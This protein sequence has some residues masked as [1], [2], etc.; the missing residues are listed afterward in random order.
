MK[1]SEELANKFVSGST[2]PILDE[3]INE[4]PEHGIQGN[5]V[6]NEH[7]F[8]SHCFGFLAGRIAKIKYQNEKNYG[9]MDYY[10]FSQNNKKPREFQKS[11]TK[12]IFIEVATNYFSKLEKEI[13]SHLLTYDKKD[14]D[15]VKFLA[16]FFRELSKR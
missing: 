7:Q 1:K 8:A 10:L 11:L 6:I 16:G 14:S 12:P 15:E 13:Y 4:F 2:F 3:M 9:Y 5:R